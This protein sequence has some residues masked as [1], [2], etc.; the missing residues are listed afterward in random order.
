MKLISTLDDEQD[1]TEYV[2]SEIEVEENRSFG[3][4]L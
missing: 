1:E 4:K 2:D 3:K